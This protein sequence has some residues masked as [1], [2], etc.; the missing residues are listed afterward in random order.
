MA[1]LVASHLISFGW[2]YLWRGEFRRTNPSELMREPYRRVILM[3]FTVIG[4]GFLV[5]ALHSPEA[6]LLLLVVLKTVTDLWGHQSVRDHVAAGKDFSAGVSTTAPR[7][8][9]E[10]ALQAALQARMAQSGQTARPLPP[11]GFV[12][13]GIFLIGC[14]CF[15]GFVTYQFVRPFIGNPQSASRPPATRA[16]PWTLDLGNAQYPNTPAAGLFRANAFHV[17]HAIFANGTLSLRQGG[18]TNSR[19]FVIAVPLR[20]NETLPGHS[21]KIL[22]DA[23]SPPPEI[24]IAW[25]ESGSKKAKMQVFTNDY[26][27]KLDFFWPQ[28]ANGKIPAMIYLCLPDSDKSYLAGKFDVL[29]RKPKSASKAEDN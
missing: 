13:I 22:T 26:A 9:V 15:A 11:L 21:F 24:K 19:T 20:T 1:A 17:E 8:S 18:G 23:S 3:Q 27:M 29:V 10:T 16:A 4:G 2:D 12:V 6:A 5:M 28:P 25:H 14:L 7:P